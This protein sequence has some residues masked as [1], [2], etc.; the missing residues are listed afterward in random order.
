MMNTKLKKWAS[1][2]IDYYFENT[3][4]DKV[5]LGIS[6][7]DLPLVYQFHETY[8]KLPNLKVTPLEDFMKCFMKKEHL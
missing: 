7:E 5:C 2:F 3:T 4:S 8:L 6:K 1:A